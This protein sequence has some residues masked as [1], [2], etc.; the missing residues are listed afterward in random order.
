MAKLSLRKEGFRRRRGFSLIVVLILS[1]IALAVIGAV[2]QYAVS[3]GGRGRVSSASAVRYNLLQDAL[4]EGRAL[5]KQ[6]MDNDGKPHRYLDKGIPEDT[7]IT[8]SDILLL[9]DSPSPT[10]Y[11]GV[12]FPL[13]NA[14]TRPMSKSDLE[15]IGILGDSGALTVRIYD[16]QYNPELV[17]EMG[18]GA[19]QISPEE[20]QLIPP[21]MSLLGE[22]DFDV[23]ITTDA[24]DYERGKK[25]GASANNAGVYLI[26]AELSVAGAGGAPARSWKLETSIVQ[27]NKLNN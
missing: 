13:G 17:P 7:P 27:A 12:D 16:M 19:D 25:A 9:T 21:S 6:S 10:D 4:E 23:A 24:P 3:S 14:I 2:M 18:A 15:R 26:R 20:L 1:L 22:D 8:A 11:P 5:L